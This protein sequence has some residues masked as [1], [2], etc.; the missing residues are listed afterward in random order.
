MRPWWDEF[1]FSSSYDITRTFL[2]VLRVGK[3]EKRSQL[4]P[5]SLLSVGISPR[6]EILESGGSVIHRE[7]FKHPTY[8]QYSTGTFSM[9]F[10][11]VFI[12]ND[13]ESF[14]FVL[15]EGIEV[16]KERQTDKQTDY[17]WYF[18]SSLRFLVNLMPT[19]P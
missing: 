10:V 4:N 3:G 17:F 7:V 2:F 8:L 15:G 14:S 18:I 11:F 19:Y 9:S 1:C 13:W 12:A 16:I 6:L 5:R